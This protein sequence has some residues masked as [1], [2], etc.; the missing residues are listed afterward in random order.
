MHDAYYADAENQWPLINKKEF[1]KG[2]YDLLKDVGILGVIDADAIAAS[3]PTKSGK[4]L[5]Q[6]DPKVVI[7]DFEEPGFTLVEQS[8]VL[9]NKKD[10]MST[11][12]F[13]PENRYITNRSVLKLQK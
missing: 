10:D 7:R 11:S 5:H 1:L 8:Y 3:D 4:G 9:A 6:V 13:L 2:I 12:V